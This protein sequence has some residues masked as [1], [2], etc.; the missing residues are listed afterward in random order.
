M[1]PDM[2]LTALLQTASSKM[3]LRE[4]SCLVCPLENSPA[5]VESYHH[6]QP[7]QEHFKAIAQID[8]PDKSAAIMYAYTGGCST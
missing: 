4:H 5:P 6:L 7:V 2:K 1:A 8:R 3:M